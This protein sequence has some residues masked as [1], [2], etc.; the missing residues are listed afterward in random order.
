MFNAN[1]P[2]QY[3]YLKPTM[4]HFPSPESIDILKE[5]G[6]TYVV[7]DTSAFAD[8]PEVEAE[9]VRNGLRLLTEQQQYR[10]YGF[11]E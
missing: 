1:Q 6:I 11:E 10:V 8:Y 2:P 9:I 4:E 3:T 5:L 7:V